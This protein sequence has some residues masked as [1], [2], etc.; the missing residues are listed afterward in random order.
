M[1][2][3]SHYLIFLLLSSFAICVYLLSKPADYDKEFEQQQS[4][5]LLLGLQAIRGFLDT[6][7]QLVAQNL[8]DVVWE[9]RQHWGNLIW[10]EDTERESEV[11]LH[12]G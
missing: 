4:Q 6:L 3:S 2:H 12:Q 5:V 7:Q 10:P 11:C 1:I 8:Q 9:E